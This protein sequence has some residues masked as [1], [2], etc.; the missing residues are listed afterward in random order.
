MS[1]SVIIVGTD[2]NVGKTIL[3]SVLMSAHDDLHYWKPIQSGLEAETDSE[4]VQRIL[5]CQAERIYPEAYKLKQPL[6]PHLSAAL[7]GIQI[8]LR[9][10]GKPQ[11]NNL[12]IE[13][14]GGILT[15]INETTLQID[16]MK[17][18][19]LPVI[20]AARSSLGTINHSLLTIGALR[21]RDIHILGVVM[22]G[23]INHHNEEA[24]TQYGNVQIIGRIPPITRF[25]LTTL[26]KTYTDYFVSF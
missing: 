24:I 2:T 6:S 16:L 8:D 14:A 7:E 23:E 11:I 21:N 4:T 15:P 10:L 18:W 5:Q 3:S 26:K 1:K 19:S 13:T 25:D 17:M 9:H 12:L 22:I 20:I